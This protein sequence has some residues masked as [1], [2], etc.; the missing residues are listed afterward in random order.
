MHYPPIPQ[1]KSC[2]CEDPCISTDDVYYAGPNLPNS[3]VN[4]NDILTEVIEK[5]DAIYAV[6]TLQRVTEIDNYTTL[7]IFAD[8]FVKIGGDGT[9]LLLDDG[10][11]LPI[12]DLPIPTFNP[13]DYDLDEFTNNNVDPFAK[14][15]DIPEFVNHW[16]KVG[17]N[18]YNN[19]SG[20]TVLLR[21]LAGGYYE[22]A[23]KGQFLQGGA[24]VDGFRVQNGGNFYYK[25]G[26]GDYSS[27]NTFGNASGSVAMT[28]TNGV[29]QSNSRIKYA[30]DLSSTYDDRSLVDKAYVDSKRPYKVYSAL[31]T[32]IGVTAP[33]AIV[34]ENTL[35]GAVTFTYVSPGIYT[36]NSSSLF[37]V[38]KT[39][40][41]AGNLGLYV[42]GYSA[43]NTTT[44]INLFTSSPTGYQ[45]EGLV[46]TF[47]EIRVYN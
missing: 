8:S 32:Q 47:L 45:D 18:I 33:T 36:I 37:T 38:D 7:P 28:T 39:S 11:V 15:S 1:R 21:G 26:Y 31:L 2:N 6:P 29:F 10:T 17:D 27:A 35:G 40:V 14:I 4:T 19:N 20:G 44:T 13:S 3:G 12:D 22:D 5:L 24:W 25:Y 30:T 9:N 42:T 34:L 46:K 16:T 23:F 43:T 41:I